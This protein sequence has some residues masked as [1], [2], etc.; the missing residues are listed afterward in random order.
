M[1]LAKVHDLGLPRPDLL[2]TL[3]LFGYAVLLDKAILICLSAALVCLEQQQRSNMSVGA[4]QM[5]FVA[6]SKLYRES[7][8][9]RFSADVLRLVPDL[10]GSIYEMAHTQH[11]LTVRL[12]G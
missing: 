7:G 10:E 6:L 1:L 3:W 4:L 9:T 11:V 12:Q 8:S 2:T 5:G